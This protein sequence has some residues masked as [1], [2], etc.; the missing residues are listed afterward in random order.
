MDW[1]NGPIGPGWLMMVAPVVSAPVPVPTMTGGGGGSL[2]QS[3][4]EQPRID[5]DEEEAIMLALMLL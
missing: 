1:R 2:V 3:I 4:I 5:V